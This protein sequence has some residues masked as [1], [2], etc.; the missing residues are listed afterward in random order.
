MGRISLGAFLAALLFQTAFGRRPRAKPHVVFI[1]ADDYGWANMGVHR[2]HPRSPAEAQGK[3]ETHTPN[4]DELVRT[5]VLLERHYAYKICSPSRSS[6]QSGRLA[7]HVNTVNTGVTYWNPEDNVSGYAGVPVNMTGIAEKMKH[8]GYET[9]LVGK[10][11]VGM[12]TPDHTPL[13]KGYDSFLGYFQHAN[14][15]WQESLPF[16]STGNVDICLN[17]FR[18]FS[19][20]NKTFKGGVDETVAAELG[21]HKSVRH[22]QK[23]GI[24]PQVNATGCNIKHPNYCLPDDCYEEAMF[25]K[26]A[27]KI[28]REHDRR[29]PLFLFYSFHLL[30]TPLQIPETYITEIDRIVEESRVDQTIPWTENRRLYAAMTLYMDTM[31]GRL[32]T[33]LK[34]QRMYSNTLIV[35]TADNGGPV[36]E[37]ASANNWPLKGGKYSDWEGGVRTNAFVSGGYVPYHRRGKKFDGVISIADWYATLSSIAGIAPDDHK[38]ERANRYLADKGLPLLPPIDS[39]SQWKHI[40]WGTN[41]R[42]DPLHLSENAL[43]W[44]PYK[45]VTDEQPYSFHAAPVYPNCSIQE[46]LGTDGPLFSDMHLFGVPLYIS[47][48]ATVQDELTM[49]SDCGP[50]GCL[51]NVEI[52]PSEHHDLSGDALHSEILFGMQQKLY[53][54]NQGNFNPD[55]GYPALEAC[56]QGADLGGFYGPFLNVDGFYEGVN[57]TEVQVTVAE[58]NKEELTRLNATL[59]RG[60]ERFI[61]HFT[62]KHGLNELVHPGPNNSFDT[63]LNGTD[64]AET[65]GSDASSTNIMYP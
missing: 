23:A 19:L 21:C 22:V 60:L 10:W 54:L 48:N 20:Y 11:D 18:D 38:A 33:A 42:S 34:E 7:V 2:E 28:I 8:G 26:Y 12:A 16:Q 56:L 46:N 41:G 59:D 14:D 58:A 29:K 64:V 61:E 17:K 52:D 55:R 35:F 44:W 47:D 62:E 9:H 53:Y 40:V 3:A 39:R 32:V 37:P 25:N 13:G 50:G 45:L 24:S 63:C 51:Y 30:H 65:N 27:L 5:G 6:L 15:Y 4:L 1:L 43:L 57:L 36:Y 49:T 31:V